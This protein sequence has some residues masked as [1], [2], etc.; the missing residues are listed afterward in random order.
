MPL[1]DVGRRLSAGFNCPQEAPHVL[2]DGRR[3]VD[4]D[5]LFG[6]VFG[7][8]ITLIDGVF[9]NWLAASF[10]NEVVAVHAGLERS[11][12]AVE[13]RRPGVLFIRR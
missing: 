11:L 4:L 2:A 7:I 12:V 13:N 3:R 8:L 9:M 1:L 5:A 6:Q 10:G